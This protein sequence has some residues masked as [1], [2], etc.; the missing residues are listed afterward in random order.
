MTQG[1]ETVWY[2]L[3]EGEVY[4]TIDSDGVLQR[5]SL[6]ALTEEALKTHGFTEAARLLDVYDQLEETFQLFALSAKGNDG[7]RVG[8]FPPPQIIA[9]TEGFDVSAYRQPQGLWLKTSGLKG[10]IRVA[11]AFNNVNTWYVCHDGQWGTTAFTVEGMRDNGMTLAELEAITPELLTLYHSTSIK[12]G[13]YL[14]KEN[15]D[16][17][18]AVTSLHIAGCTQSWRKAQRFVDYGC[19]MADNGHKLLVT[20]LKNGDYKVNYLQEEAGEDR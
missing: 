3:K 7:V 13:Y 18:L 5:L 6:S 9:H 20:I 16:D 14:A 10:T 19:A 1:Q 4:E 12:L 11:I 15:L 2:L 17:D 8:Y